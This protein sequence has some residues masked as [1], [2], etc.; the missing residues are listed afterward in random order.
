M[1]A[2]TRLKSLARPSTYRRAWRTVERRVLLKRLTALVDQ[3]A[4][5]SLRRKYSSWAAPVPRTAPEKYLD[6]ATYLELNLRRVQYLELHRRG[7]RARSLRILDIGCGAGYFLFICKALGHRGSGLDVGDVPLYDECMAMFELK[8]VDARIEPFS[9]LPAFE[10]QF[11]WV[12]AF[13]IEFNRYDAQRVWGRAEW[14]F[15]LDDVRRLLAPG[16]RLFLDLNPTKDVTERDEE[17]KWMTCYTPELLS[18]F[19]DHRAVIDRSRVLFPPN[20]ER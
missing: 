3:Q 1:R 11:D 12:T 4:L 20:A 18:L 16:G 19:R 8:R 15:F 5:E 6:V 9:P 10:G 14:S 2:S 13:A 7:Q 17:K